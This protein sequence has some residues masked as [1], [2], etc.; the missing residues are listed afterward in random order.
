MKKL[1]LLSDIKSINAWCMFYTAHTKTY[2][3][4]QKLPDNQTEFA[5]WY[6]VVAAFHQILLNWDWMFNIDVLLNFFRWQ[7]LKFLFE[8][9]SPVIVNKLQIL[10]SETATCSSRFLWSCRNKCQALHDFCHFTRATK[11]NTGL[12][13]TLQCYGRVFTSSFEKEQEAMKLALNWLADSGHTGKVLICTDSQANW[14]H[15]E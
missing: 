14:Q 15:L 9:K 8:K 2:M 13:L 4:K 5:K 11:S 12:T 1:S 6:L 7:Q 10:C 3:R